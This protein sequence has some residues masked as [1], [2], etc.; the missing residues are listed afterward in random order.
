MTLEAGPREIEVRATLKGRLAGAL[1]DLPRSVRHCFAGLF[2]GARREGWITSRGLFVG[3][4]ECEWGWPSDWDALRDAGLIEYRLEDV[5]NH[6]NV[7]GTTTHLHWSITEQGWRVREDDIA[8]SNALSAAM[9]E[10]G[11]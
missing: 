3:K 11:R 10:D 7:G 1:H 2:N 6:P 8:W 9:D 4:A 5:P